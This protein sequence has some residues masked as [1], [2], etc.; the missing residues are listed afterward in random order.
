MDKDLRRRGGRR[1]IADRLTQQIN[2]AASGNRQAAADVLPLVY[3]ELKKLATIRLSSEA[4]GHSL[5][6]TG[7]V[8]EAYLRLIG[9]GDAKRWEN[10]GHF[11]AAAAEAMRRIL[12]EAARRKRARKRSGNRI[13][14]DLD[15]V[16]LPTEHIRED[17]VALDDAL[18]KLKTEDPVA[19]QLI[20]LKY[21]GGMKLT[22][23]AE[24]LNLS[25]RTAE[26]RWSYAKAWLFD[27]IRRNSDSNS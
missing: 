19:S 1:I 10:R 4:P 24:L 13:P 23:A 12:V 21:F 14:H 7:L 22:E 8:H 27:E 3:D 11:F 2:D 18:Q 15:H 25:Q 5:Q 16:E 17:L 6:A 20:D 9:K 26:R